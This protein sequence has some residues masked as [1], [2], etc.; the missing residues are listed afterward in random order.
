M[1]CPWCHGKGVAGLEGGRQ[2][3]CPE[4]GGCGLVH[5]CEGLREQPGGGAAAGDV[6]QEEGGDQPSGEGGR[7][8]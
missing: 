3:P 2:A 8:P 4:C 5:C 6:A 7:V 1:L